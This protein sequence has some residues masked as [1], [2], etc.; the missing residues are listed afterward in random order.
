MFLVAVLVAA[1]V[2]A[3]SDTTPPTAPG[4]PRVSD[5]TCER[6]T[7]S[8][9]AASD[10]VGVA[11]YDVYHDGQHMTSVAGTSADLT[12]VPG[13]AWGLYVNARDAAGN[14]SQASPTVTVTVPDCQADT[15]PPAVPVGVGAGEWGTAIKV[16]WVRSTDNVAVTGYEVLRDGVQVSKVAADTT[17]YADT[18]LAAVTRYEYRVVARDAAGN[19]SAPSAPAH[20]M[21]GPFRVAAVCSVTEVASDDDLP[22]GLTTLPNGAVLYSRRDAFDIV[23]LDPATG[24]KTSIGTVPDAAG[25]DGEGGVMGIAVAADFA[26]HPWLYV[27]HTTATDNRVVRIRYVDGVLSGSPQIVISGIPR[28]KYHNGGRLRF[29]PDGKLYIATG[30]AQRR[31]SAQDRNSLA[32][33]VLRLDPDGKV[34]PDNPFGNA[35]WSYGHR[36]PQGLAFDSRGRLWAQEFGNHLADETNLVVR[37]GN[38]GWPLCEGPCDNPSFV[39]P[40]RTYTTKE[41][42]CSGI[43]VVG[44]ALYVACLRGARLYRMPI[45]GEELGEAEQYLHGA[46]GRLRTVEPTGDGDLWLTTSTKGDKD[47]VAGNSDERVLKVVLRR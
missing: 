10:A 4:D 21:T 23:R 45:N 39:P 1:S 40:K 3:A 31:D 34:P 44:D 9:T 13:A 6:L 29:G 11:A 43:A 41:G 17:S 28:N 22:W 7:L 46:H 37:G 18:G 12:V 20:A 25:S 19:R 15:E 14:V 16:R 26:E 35:V 2:G 38:Y 32:G 42:S 27:M 5:L 24:T 30:D 36:N 47:S 33:K 8:R